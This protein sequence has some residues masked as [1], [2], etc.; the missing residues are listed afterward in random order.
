[1]LQDTLHTALRPTAQRFKWQGD[2][3]LCG[4]DN[5]QKKY[6][7]TH[8]KGNMTTQYCSKIIK[9]NETQMETKIFFTESGGG[10]EKINTRLKLP[11]VSTTSDDL[12]A[13]TF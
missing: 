9:F 6:N 7:A 5:K 2:I 8:L 1:M 10:G 12:M 3:Y 11:L 4:P 13:H